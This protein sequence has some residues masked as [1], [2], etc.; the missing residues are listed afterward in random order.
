[1]N[2]ELSGI[3][4]LGSGK[5]REIF[6][7]E[8]LLLLVATDRLSAFD[9]V[10]AQGIPGK[11]KVLTQLSAFWFEKTRQ[12]VPNHLVTL[13]LA[14]FPEPL[15]SH[16]ELAG[17]A[18]LCHKAQ[19]VPME[20]IVRGYLEGSAWKEYQATGKV[21]GIAMPPGLKRRSRLPEPIFTP[22]T[23]A[24]HGLHD[25]NITFEECSR[26]IGAELAGQLRDKSLALYQFAHQY[27]DERGITLA[28]TKFEFGLRG[29]EMIL[30]DE[31]L[32]PD[33]S[34]FWV[35]GSFEAGGEPISYDKQYVRDY[36]EATGWNKEPP[37]PPLPEDVVTNTARR[38]AEIFE[39]ITGRTLAL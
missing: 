29:G 2:V 20:C 25:E 30:I 34:R 37:A 17:R 6:A 35:K 13:D 15:R 9:V 23:K 1:M 22:S 33:S 3:E 5:V 19:V 27:L 36:L 38:Y 16:A 10:F 12:I 24:E 4:H 28:D 31:A 11:G 39:K 32:T 26:R 21:S 14:Q 8:D 18:T 7:W